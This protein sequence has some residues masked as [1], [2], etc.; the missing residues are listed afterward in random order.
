[1]C[2]ACASQRTD[3]IYEY[4]CVQEGL[5]EKCPR[6]VVLPRRENENEE[7]KNRKEREEDPTGGYERT[8]RE[9]MNLFLLFFRGPHAKQGV[10]V[11]ILIGVQSLL[12]SFELMYECILE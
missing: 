4:E 5:E 3:A 2:A 7:K 9:A 11:E 1:M 6:E 10:K 12:C 8:P